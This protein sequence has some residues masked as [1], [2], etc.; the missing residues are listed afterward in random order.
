MNKSINQ[1]ALKD[2]S[3]KWDMVSGHDTT[4]ALI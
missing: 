2:G 1:S 3:T 4:I